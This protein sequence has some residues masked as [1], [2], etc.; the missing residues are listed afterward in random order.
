M[1]LANILASLVEAFSV[2]LWTDRLTYRQTKLI[3]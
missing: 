1:K 2:L 3:A